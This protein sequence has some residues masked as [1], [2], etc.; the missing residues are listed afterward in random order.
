[1]RLNGTHDGI[2]PGYLPGMLAENHA[3]TK[4]GAY[5][6]RLISPAAPCLLQFFQA[7]TLDLALLCGQTFNLDDRCIGSAFL[8]DM[9]QDD[10]IGFA[11][12]LF[13]LPLQ[14]GA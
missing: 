1:M 14:H 12:T 6:S 2:M 8:A 11:F 3:S 10:D 5:G 9:G 7:N 13:R 4:T